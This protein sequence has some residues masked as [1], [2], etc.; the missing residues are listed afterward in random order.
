[1]EVALSGV[2]SFTIWKNTLFASSSAGGEIGLG[3]IYFRRSE[4]AGWIPFNTTG[5]PDR[6]DFDTHKVLV[7]NGT[8]WAARGVNGFLYRYDTAAM[9][10]GGRDYFTPH[11]MGTVTDMQY[12]DGRLLARWDGQVIGSA[13]TGKSWTYDTVGLKT[14]VN[15]VFA[16]KVRL[17]FMGSK[18]DYVVTNVRTGAGEGQ[19]TIQARARGAAVGSS[20]ATLDQERLPVPAFANDMLEFNGSLFVATDQGVYTKG[21][22]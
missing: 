5:L 15:P 4:G 9:A 17:I 16:P 3:S 6:L 13:D 11:R 8:L 19:A 22:E 10:W 1:L 18:R 2:G 21:V 12:N 14:V 20:W 7:V